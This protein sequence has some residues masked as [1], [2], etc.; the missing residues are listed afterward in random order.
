MTSSITVS[1]EFTLKW[2]FNDDGTTIDFCLCLNKKAWIG[3]GF[4]KNVFNIFMFR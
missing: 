1:T 2:K 3:L 4:G